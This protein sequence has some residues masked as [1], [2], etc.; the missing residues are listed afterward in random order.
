MARRA[1][2]KKSRIIQT[3]FLFLVIGCAGKNSGKLE[4]DQID[5]QSFTPDNIYQLLGKPY[6]E[7]TVTRNNREFRTMVYAYSSQ[8]GSPVYE[9]VIAARAQTFFFEGKPLGHE[10]ESSLAI[11]ATDF[12][13]TKI[14]SVRKGVST[15]HEVVNLIGKPGGEYIY[16][17]TRSPGEKTKVYL[18]SHVKEAGP[19]RLETYV[20]KLVVSYDETGLVTGMDF[21]SRGSR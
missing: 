15:I 18:F 4:D 9:D 21:K 10:F 14:E 2:I 11:D 3:I 7:V 6:R 13:E 1:I 16:P 17:L 19:M 8:A 20:E 12:D 5:F